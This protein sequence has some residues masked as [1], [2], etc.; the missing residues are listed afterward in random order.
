[1]PRCLMTYFSQGGT[2][3]LVAENIASG[4]RSAEYEVDL[5]NISDGAP[6]AVDGYGLLGVGLPVYYY[7]PP[8]NIADYLRELPDLEGLP[9]FVFVLHGTYRFDAGTAVR[10]SLARKG[11]REVG[12]FHSYGLERWV[13]YL[14]EGYVFSPDHPRDDEL[15]RAVAFGREV[16]AHAAGGEY[17]RPPDDAPPSPVYRLERFVTNRWLAEQLYSRLFRVDAAKCNSCGVC[18][19][20]C[21]NGNI[22]RDR[23]GRPVWGRNCLLCLTCEM[24]C[25][26]RA[27]SSPASWR[28]LRP[29]MK[30]NAGRA[31]SDPGIDHAR[32]DRK[33]WQPLDGSGAGA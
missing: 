31:S 7:R 3:A 5:C 33:T 28:I 9:V 14:N 20:R 10:R 2:T 8:F 12:Y 24:E 21:P 6:P 29:I 23:N 19:D 18:L 26:Q 16:A 4:L 30:F 13:G 17:R 22:S 27:V 11:G 25:P 1:M 15:S 32:V